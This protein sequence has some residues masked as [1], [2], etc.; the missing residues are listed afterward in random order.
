MEKLNIVGLTEEQNSQLNYIYRKLKRDSEQAQ[1][2]VAEFAQKLL[3]GL[4][5]LDTLSW[6]EATF[7]YAAIFEVNRPFINNIEG[8]LADYNAADAA[9]EDKTEIVAR[10]AKFVDGF[11]D[12]IKTRVTSDM[13]NKSFSSMTTSNLAS[14]YKTTALASLLDIYY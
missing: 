14:H 13:N 2:K 6:S 8:A 11:E 3:E 4:H 1:A 10:F 7:K 12:Q 9:G 5:P